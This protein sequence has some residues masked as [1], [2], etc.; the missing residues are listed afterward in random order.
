MPQE[1]HRYRSFFPGG[2]LSAR[3]K[4]AMRARETEKEEEMSRGARRAL[5]IRVME[6]E[7]ALT[8]F[9]SSSF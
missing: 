5:G 9:L 6:T 4:S 8:A 3:E 1:R 7:S 2:L